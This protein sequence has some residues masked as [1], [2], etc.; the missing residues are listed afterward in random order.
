MSDSFVDLLLVRLGKEEEKKKVLK[1][2]IANLDLSVTEAESAVNNSPSVV[3]EAV[4]MNEAR[5]IQKDLYPYID[6][7]PRLEDETIPGKTT[8]DEEVAEVK[9]DVPSVEYEKESED[10]V[11]EDSIHDYADHGVEDES[12]FDVQEE[13]DEEA[14]IITTASEEI[15]STSRCHICGRTPTDS[16]RLAP[17]RTCSKLTCR[18]CFDRIAHV[19]NHCANE[20]KTVDRVNEGMGTDSQEGLE[21]DTEEEHAE[22]QM[23]RNPPQAELLQ[24]LFFLFLLLPLFFTFWIQWGFLVRKYILMNLQMPMLILQQ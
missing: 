9:P 3:R 21:F 12:D 7:L 16:E 23:S 6:L 1:L 18:T 22:K 10:P 4:P 17:C 5:V 11:V 13:E 24:L 14:I 20:G 19:C 8:D 15:L 2:L